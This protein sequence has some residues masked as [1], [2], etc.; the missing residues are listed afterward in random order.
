[1]LDGVVVRQ[2]TENVPAPVTGTVSDIAVRPGDAVTEGQEVATVTLLPEPTPSPSPTGFGS[3]PSPAPAVS[4]I[5]ETVTAPI[6]G[7]VGQLS[8]AK[9][10]VVVSGQQLLTVIPGQFDV[11][12]SVPQD[13]LYRFYSQPLS[14]QAV[15]PHQSQPVDCA[16]KSIGGN[17]PTSGATAVLQQEIDLRCTLPVGTSVFPG[18]RA[19]VV[20]VTAEV[21]DALTLP[22]SA[23]QRQGT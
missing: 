2:N 3:S 19:T 18:V 10:Q 21:D 4:P 22:A 17:L 14:V 15:I 12:A 20:A 11:I 9:G 8:A 6:A 1:N 7:T 5:D 13:Q 23:V 16:F